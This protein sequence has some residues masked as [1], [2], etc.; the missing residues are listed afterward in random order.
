MKEDSNTLSAEK[1]TPLFCETTSTHIVVP[2][3]RQRCNPTGINGHNL[4]QMACYPL[5]KPKAMP[6]Q[7][8]KMFNVIIEV[9]IDGTVSE[10]LKEN[11]FIP[12]DDTGNPVALPDVGIAKHHLDVTSLGIYECDADLKSCAKEAVSTGV[13]SSVSDV[14]GCRVDL[15]II[16]RNV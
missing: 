16:V 13:V 11:W 2:L 7:S 8:C 3:S 14:I 4:L 12:L 10:L 15:T 9:S 1:D 6:D 5:L